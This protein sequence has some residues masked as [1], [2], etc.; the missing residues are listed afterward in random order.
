MTSNPFKLLLALALAPAITALGTGAAHATEV[1]RP[2]AEFA[3]APPILSATTIE[4]AEEPSSPAP[5]APLEWS[6]NPGVYES[7]LLRRFGNPLYLE[8]RRQIGEGELLEA[9]RRDA[10]QMWQVLESFI[11]LLS[12]KGS[13][14]RFELASQ[15]GDALLRIDEGTWAA[16]RVGGEAYPLAAAI[17]NLRTWLLKEWRVSS[18][19]DPGV[20]ALLDAEARIPIVE[21]ESLAIRFLALIQAGDVDEQEGPIRR[22]EF[23][24]ALMNEDP[25]SIRKVYAALRGELKSTM[26]KQLTLLL[27][28]IAR[29]EIEF[30]GRDRKVAVVTGLLGLNPADLGLRDRPSSF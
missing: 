10:E 27:E 29:E 3:S 5:G 1:P 23:G 30:E 24:T 15:M 8:S 16:L 2:D 20:K 19:A 12:D 14:S 7:D 13:M 21:T 17:Q 6:E 22:Y 25:A 11:D 9:K 18:A 28:E 26:Q 4:E